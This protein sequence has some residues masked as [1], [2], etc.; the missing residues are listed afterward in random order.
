[1]PHREVP[2][3]GGVSIAEGPLD[4][5]HGAAYREGAAQVAQLVE[6]VTENHGV[7]GSTPSLGTIPHLPRTTQLRPF[8]LAPVAICSWVGPGALSKKVR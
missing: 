8:G 6:H 2:V 4:R 3:R 1:M 7:G 5:P